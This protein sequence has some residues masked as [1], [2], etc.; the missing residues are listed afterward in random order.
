MTNGAQQVSARLFEIAKIHCCIR[1]TREHGIGGAVLL[2][3][4]PECS[5][6]FEWQEVPYVGEGE[7]GLQANA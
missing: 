5:C 2:G 3:G 4:T 1:R 7:S 6:L